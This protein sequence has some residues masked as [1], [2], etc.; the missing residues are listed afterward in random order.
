M[1][2]TL[3]HGSNDIASWKQQVLWGRYGLH[4]CSQQFKSCRV[5][6]LWV[7]LRVFHKTVN[8]FWCYVIAVAPFIGD[9]IWPGFEFKGFDSVGIGQRFYGAST[10]FLPIFTPSVLNSKTMLWYRNR[11]RWDILPKTN[12]YHFS[13]LINDPHIQ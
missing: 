6:S 8:R 1:M 12:V 2:L 4:S 5:P 10:F 9:Q 3:L 11:S 7:Y 13:Y